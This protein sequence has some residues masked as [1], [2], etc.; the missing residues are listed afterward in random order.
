V[1]TRRLLVLP[2]VLTAMGALQLAGAMSAGF[3]PLD[4]LLLAVGLLAAAGLGVARGATAAVSVRDGLP[5]LRYRPATLLLWAATVAVRF[6][7]TLLAHSTV[8]L[9]AASGPATRTAQVFRSDRSIIASL[10]PTG[11][12]RQARDRNSFSMVLVSRVS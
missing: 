5:W 6:L 8:A 7:L 1:S 10:S 4:A 12:G 3:R 9:V 2:G 11:A